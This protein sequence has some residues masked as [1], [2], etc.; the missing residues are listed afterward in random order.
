MQFFFFFNVRKTWMLLTFFTNHLCFWVLPFVTFF[1][2]RFCLFHWQD[3]LAGIGA[4]V[5]SCKTGQFHSY[6][7]WILLQFFP[8]FFCF[9]PPSH[10]FLLHI[11]HTLLFPSLTPSL[12]S[13]FLHPVKHRGSG[14]KIPCCGRCLPTCWKC[15]VM[16]CIPKSIIRL[17]WL[18]VYCPQL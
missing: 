13:S 2:T 12:W 4:P 16:H 11:I 5:L 1:N 9:L 7:L 18:R 17:F 6:F 15:I 8:C 10:V 14:P 3:N